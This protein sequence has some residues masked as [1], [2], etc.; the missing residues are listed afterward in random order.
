[1]EFF[2]ADTKT[3]TVTI[4]LESPTRLELDGEQMAVEGEITVRTEYLYDAH[5]GANPTLKQRHVELELE[6]IRPE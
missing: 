5:D 4:E 3:E 6:T 1:M 2:E